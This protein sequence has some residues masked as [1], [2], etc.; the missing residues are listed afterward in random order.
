MKE[1]FEERHSLH[2]E[3]ALFSLRSNLRGQKSGQRRAAPHSALASAQHH[4]VLTLD[5]PP[6]PGRLLQNESLHVM[7][8]PKEVGLSLSYARVWCVRGGRDGGV[9]V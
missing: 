2:V 7:I 6:H 9:S 8:A 5:L 4:K 1:V 3:L